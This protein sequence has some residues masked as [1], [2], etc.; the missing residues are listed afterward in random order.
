MRSTKNY[1]S[2]RFMRAMMAAASVAMLA[3]CGSDST[4]PKNAGVQG[5]YTLLSVNGSPLPYTVPNTGEDV[6]I[7]Q[8]AT[9]T[10]GADSTYAVHATGTENGSASTI[11]TDAGHY[12]VSGNQV[13]FTSTMIS[14]AHYTANYATTPGSPTLTATI[15]GLFVG[16][17]DISFTLVFAKSG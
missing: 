11:V 14:G 1:P 8:D 9:I 3:A 2:A 5:T 16:S 7:V 13:T 6:R 17:S 4:G 10:L 12:T 15:A